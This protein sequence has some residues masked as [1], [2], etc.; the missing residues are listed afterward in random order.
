MPLVLKIGPLPEVFGGGT[1]TPF[2]RR[3]V[4]NFASASLN[5]GLLM[6]L[7]PA[8]PPPT[9]AP[10]FLRA[11]SYCARVTPL[12]SWGPPAPP[13]NPRGPLGPLGPPGG[14]LGK[15]IPFFCRHSRSALKRAP[16]CPVAPVPAPPGP[17][18]A[19]PGAP[20][21]AVPGPVAPFAGRPPEPVAEAFAFV[22]KLLEEP[23]QAAR[24]RH[25]SRRA[26]TTAVVAGL[27]M[28]LRLLLSL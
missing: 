7:R 20:A 22:E 16:P 9:G 4:A 8:K 6:P 24:P 18:G 28:G 2:A 3:H 15:V 1:F 21:P 17:V 14:R 11:A 19:D 27:R 26:S 5:T 10:H 23:P 12:G 25:A 13:R